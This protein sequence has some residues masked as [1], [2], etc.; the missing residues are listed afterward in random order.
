MQEYNKIRTKALAQLKSEG[1]N[2]YPH[3]FHVSISLEEFIEKYSSISAGE[4]LFDVNV[5]VSG[6]FTPSKVFDGSR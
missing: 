1:F 6:M 2:P 3:K 4:T 5:S